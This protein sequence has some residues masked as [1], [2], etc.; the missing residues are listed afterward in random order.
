MT[1]CRKSYFLRFQNAVHSCTRAFVMKHIQILRHCKCNTH[2]ITAIKLLLTTT[3]TARGQISICFTFYAFLWLQ[4]AFYFMKLLPTTPTFT[5]VWQPEL[6]HSLFVLLTLSIIL[7]CHHLPVLSPI[8]LP[9]HVGPVPVPI[10]VFTHNI[11]SFPFAKESL[12]Y[13]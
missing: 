6:S 2:N 9:T 8:T 7:L 13:V 3:P 10:P 4:I 5:F 12:F 1:L 11:I